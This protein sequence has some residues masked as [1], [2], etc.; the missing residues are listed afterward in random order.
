[1]DSQRP[2]PAQGMV[3]VVCGRARAM[4]AVK[5]CTAAG[6]EVPADGCTAHAA[7]TKR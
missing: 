7:A 6:H 5:R 3:M 1:M 4:G 2:L